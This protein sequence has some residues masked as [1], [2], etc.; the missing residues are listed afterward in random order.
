MAAA[1]GH[2]IR[3]ET[4]ELAQDI[5]HAAPSR[6]DTQFVSVALDLQF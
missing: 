3:G 4:G 6:P 2:E 5:A 1:L